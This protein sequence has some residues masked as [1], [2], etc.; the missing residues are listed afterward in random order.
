[1]KYSEAAIKAKELLV[2]KEHSDE[3]NEFLTKFENHETTLKLV[4]IQER[5]EDEVK[6]IKARY[7]ILIDRE[8]STV[9]K[10]IMIQKDEAVNNSSDVE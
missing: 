9:T 8:I 1:M 2:K 4:E 3:E 10:V 6:M 7:Q 5:F